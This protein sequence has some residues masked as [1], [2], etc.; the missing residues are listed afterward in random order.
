[1]NADRVEGTGPRGEAQITRNQ[2]RFPHGAQG[3]PGPLGLPVHA[4]AVPDD[5]FQGHQVSVGVPSAY[6]GECPE[7]PH[8][9]L[10][11]HAW[12]VEDRVQEGKRGQR[13]GAVEDVRSHFTQFHRL[14]SRVVAVVQG[15]DPVDVL[16]ETPHAEQVRLLAHGQEEALLER[17]PAG[18]PACRGG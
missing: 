8:E 13:A 16:R 10:D 7:F 14:T 9:R 2:V 5:R 17:D 11:G 4:A 12:V 6:P 3:R 18:R 15:D 1:M